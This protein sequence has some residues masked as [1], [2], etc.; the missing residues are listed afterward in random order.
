MYQIQGTIT[1]TEIANLKATDILLTT[2]IIEPLDTGS[3]IEVEPTESE[4]EEPVEQ[5][6]ESEP[7]EV[8]AVEGGNQSTTTTR[9]PRSTSGRKR[10]QTKTI[11]TQL[12]RYILK[13]QS[14]VRELKAQL[15]QCHC[16]DPN[17]D[18]STLALTIISII[19]AIFS[20]ISLSITTVATIRNQSQTSETTA[21]RAPVEPRHQQNEIPL[22]HLYNLS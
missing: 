20:C 6:V 22:L 10:S 17:K 14:E 16:Q 13:L 7:E 11:K 2:T 15:D 19:A 8:K 4:P 18:L 5:S 12:S 3:G 9:K 1:E 21:A